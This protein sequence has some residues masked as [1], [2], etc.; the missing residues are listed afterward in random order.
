MVRSPGRPEQA[1]RSEAVSERRY[2][3]ARVSNHEALGDRSR[4]STR[5]QANAGAEEFLRVD[6]F[7]VDAGFVMQMRSGRATG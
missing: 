2:K 4:F 7:A 5:T 3:T 1:E 6:G